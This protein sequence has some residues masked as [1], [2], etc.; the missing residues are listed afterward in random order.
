MSSLKSFGTGNW[1][2]SVIKKTSETL[3]LVEM[4]FSALCTE[5]N[6]VHPKVSCSGIFFLLASTILI[7]FPQLVG[8][9]CSKLL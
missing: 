9:K 5:T 7:H 6:F 4:F 2:V 1:I 8:G 3:P